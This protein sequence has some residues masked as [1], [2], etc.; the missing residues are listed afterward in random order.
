MLLGGVGVVLMLKLTS[1]A[2]T[3]PS[4]DN[5]GGC[6][7][8]IS[9]SPPKLY[10]G[11]WG[12]LTHTEPPS[13]E[14]S[15]A[16]YKACKAASCI[17]AV[18][19]YGRLNNQ[20]I[21]LSHLVGLTVMSKPRRRLVLS[22]MT[23]RF[24]EQGFDLTGVFDGWACVDVSSGVSCPKT[25]PM[26]DAY[27]ASATDESNSRGSVFSSWHK[28]SRNDRQEN[29]FHGNVLAQIFMRPQP[30]IKQ[31]ME[32]FDRKYQLSCTGYLAVHLRG[33][34][35]TCISR[36]NS[37][38]AALNQY[39]DWDAGSASDLCSMSDSL[40]EKHLA[41]LPRG[42]QVVLLHDR[43]NKGRASA[44]VRKFNAKV[45]EGPKG[46]FVDLLLAFKSSYFLGNPASSFASNIAV[47]R[48]AIETHIHHTLPSNMHF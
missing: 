27:F 47:A 26:K 6:K 21:S 29:L 34:E 39:L 9:W 48:W 1:T 25:V 8:I 33:L 18:G 46:S 42:T 43:Q 23:H 32:E 5:T 11:W 2:V 17:Q 24:V 15:A 7:P 31:A 36:V 16:F 4:R 19:E 28:N 10:N 30:E 20:L 13:S 41:K 3:V 12:G 38:N 44:I 22:S 35:G 45:Y 40:I 37:H 14:E